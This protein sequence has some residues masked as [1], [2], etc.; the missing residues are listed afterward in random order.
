M[1]KGSHCAGFDGLVGCKSADVLISL[2]PPGLW[3]SGALEDSL[4]DGKFT[5]I[6]TTYDEV[7]ITAK[8]GCECMYSRLHQRDKD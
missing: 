1:G 8:H 4:T 6:M 7:R 5:C 2:W 3:S